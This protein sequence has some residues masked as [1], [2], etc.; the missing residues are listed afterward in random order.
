MEQINSLEEFFLAIKKYD[1]S[2]SFFRGQSN[3]DYPNISP[4]INRNKGFYENERSIYSETLK[5]RLNDFIALF[6]PFEKLAKMQH[7]GIPTRLIDVTTNPLIALYFA[8]ENVGNSKDGEVFLF[9]SQNRDIEEDIVKFIS[10]LSIT[11]NYNISNLKNL[12][13]ET[14]GYM[15]S[16][17]N[18]INYFKD[19]VFIKYDSVLEKQNI[20]SY[21]QNG[22]FILCSNVITNEE[23]TNKIRNIEKSDVDMIFRIPFEFKQKIKKDLDE[24]YGINE[25][26]VYPELSSFANYIKRKYQFDQINISN[27]FKI[28]N[29]SES[30]NLSVKRVSLEVLLTDKIHY[31]YIEYIIKDIND[32][33]SKDFDI[34]RLFIFSNE[35]DRV[36]SNWIVRTIWKKPNLDK[37]YSP[38][39]FG[40]KNSYGIYREYSSD[41]SVM[42][43]FYDSNIFQEDDF[44]LENYNNIFNEILPIYYEILTHV[45][46]RNLS[47]IRELIL[48]N[49]TKINNLYLQISDMGQSKSKEFSEY[50]SNYHLFICEI[51]NMVYDFNNKNLDDKYLLYKSERTVNELISRYKTITDAYKK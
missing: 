36:I 16:D 44:L 47:A 24:Q 21:N 13:I 7:Y 34:V 23:I 39:T 2:K 25:S 46:T 41:F 32:K 49:E 48:S 38:G 15:I 22:A 31:D 43:E 28:I 12:F 37:K 45:E 4:S 14:F 11:N 40:V 9:L 29:I 5:E 35:A 51:D 19:N 26:F 18:F 50:L 30:T 8:V 42:R 10:L 27:L 20:R 17:S 33:F 3:C 1:T 6:N